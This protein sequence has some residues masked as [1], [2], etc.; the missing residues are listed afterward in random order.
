MS[1]YERIYLYTGWLDRETVATRIAAAID[2]WVTHDEHANVFVSRAMV[3]VPDGQV[4]GEVCENIF[5]ENP[6]STKHPGVIDLYDMSFGL[7][8]SPRPAEFQER[9]AELIFREITKNLDWP[10]VLTH[11]D[12]DL[13]AATWSPT[14]GR[15]DFPRGTTPDEDDQELWAPYAD[16]ARLLPDAE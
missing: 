15:H 2:G 1:T 6:P 12:G 8:C 14:L 4:W 5:Y 11:A 9:E 7:R 13:L 10:A 3:S 16:P